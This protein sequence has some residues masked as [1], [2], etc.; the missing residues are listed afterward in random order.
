MKFE[1][2]IK[3]LE[4]K[5][6]EKSNDEFVKKQHEK[7]KL[8]ARE[9]IE[10]LVDK[11]SFVELDPFVETRFNDFGLDKKK[12]SGDCV[13][14]GFA[15]INGKQVCLYSQDF[16][17]SGGTLGEMHG[18]KIV[19]II[20]L[21]QKIGCPIISII[22]SGGARIQE[23]IVSL[24]GYAT[25]F[26]AMVKASG[27]IPQISIMVGPSAGGACYAPGLSDFIFMVEGISQMYI[28]GP[29][30][31]KS[32]T[33]ESV[34]FDN[35]GGAHIHTEKSGCAHFISKT[36]I[37]CFENVKNF[38]EYLPQNNVE[39][40]S[41]EVNDEDELLEDILDLIPEENEKGYDM[42]L[43]IG[44]IFDKDSFFEVHRTFALNV[45]VGFARLNGNTVGVV[46]NQVKHMAGVLDIDASDKIA[47]FVR[48]CD[49]FNIPIV[50]LVDTPGY[51]PGTVQEHQG[52]IRHGAKVLYA[53]SEAT[54]PKI[55]IILR[56]AFGGAYIALASRGLGYDSVIAWPM[57][58]IAVMGVEQAVK[59]IY[60]KQIAESNDPVK[61]EKEKIEEMKEKFLD[62]FEAAKLGQVDMIIEPSKTRKIIIQ[63]LETLAMKRE[64]A[65]PKKHGT[66]P[67]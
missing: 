12:Y 40:C 32:V 25:I 48:F 59:I 4:L 52:I 17:R 62:P 58:Q 29:D 64:T 47:R 24:D 27:I 60:K 57:A 35:L 55:S 41:I 19:K 7:G 63:C 26:R 49:A 43:V 38:L 56:K 22:D 15:K 10:L 30:V 1:K 14:S 9:R 34:N 16:S 31:I 53:Y 23:G 46:A 61:A 54:V 36:E 2:Q 13:I 6:L 37:E 51:L 44:K 42:K 33:G 45:I 21:A 3:K 18:R 50:N 11:N 5:N 39:D 66:M 28:T 67:L 20:E 8:D 65:F